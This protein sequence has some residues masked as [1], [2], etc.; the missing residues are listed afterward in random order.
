MIE[1]APDLSDNAALRRIDGDLPLV[2]R[3]ALRLSLA[4]KGHWV[5][6]GYTHDTHA[7]RVAKWL[8]ENLN[9]GPGGSTADGIDL[10]SRIVEA[11]VGSAPLTAV[12]EL[13]EGAIGV[14][15]LMLT[16]DGEAH[17]V[18]TPVLNDAGVIA[19]LV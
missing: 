1:L 14:V 7:D 4:Y 2:D 9:T 18:S 15:N 12:S 8:P 3:Y 19:P 6:I 16:I 10:K 13:P 17:L 5:R 11:C